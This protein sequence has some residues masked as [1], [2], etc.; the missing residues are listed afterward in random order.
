MEPTS[1]LLGVLI[2]STKG[3]AFRAL[4]FGVAWWRG[5]KRIASLEAAMPQAEELT[6][7]IERFEAALDYTTSALERLLEGQE[8]LRRALP[9]AGLDRGPSARS[10]ERPG[11]T[12]H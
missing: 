3:L 5:R 4:G 2:A 9:P 6:D 8:Q 12:P 1:V 11:D 10:P 7:R